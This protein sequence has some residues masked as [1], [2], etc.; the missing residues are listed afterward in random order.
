M[1]IFNGDDGDNVIDA[2]IDPDTIDGGEGNDTL[3]G[4]LDA[5]ILNGGAG[6]GDLSG[7]S[8]LDTLNGATQTLSRAAP[9]VMTASMAG[10]AS[11][12]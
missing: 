11:T 5:D 2:R 9:A 6:I 3:D 4:G 8:G 10:L 7:G 1:S 12:G